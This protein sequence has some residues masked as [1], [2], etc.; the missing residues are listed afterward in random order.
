[1]HMANVFI[2]PH[3][4]VCIEIT[5]KLLTINYK[6]FF[7]SFTFNKKNLSR[8]TRFVAEDKIS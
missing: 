8:F 3:V 7:F 6:M 1:M 4:Y 2:D 5:V